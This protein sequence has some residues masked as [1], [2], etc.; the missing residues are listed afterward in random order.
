MPNQLGF[1]I[2]A[3]R[4]VQCHACQVACKAANGIELGVTWRRVM[5]VWSGTFPKVTFTTISIACMH[6]ADPACEAVCP[7]GAISK[8]VQDGIVVVDQNKCIGCRFCLSACPFGAPQF[9]ASG[10]M[11]KCVLCMD[12]LS[13][14]KQPACVQTC[15]A[16]ALHVGT[17]DELSKM[18]QQKSAQ[19]LVGATQPSVFISSK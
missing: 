6:C 10:R 15:P 9:G 14:G 5:P 1:Y 18:A 8:R 19:K 11:Q 2:E 16:N 7:T 13:A 3:D 17:L 4:C 12:R